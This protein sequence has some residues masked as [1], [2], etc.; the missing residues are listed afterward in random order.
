VSFTGGVN[1]KAS[2]GSKLERAEHADLITLPEGIPGTNC[3]NCRFVDHSTDP[4][5]YT[6]KHVE[7]DQEVNPRMCCKYWDKH[8]VKRAWI[9]ES[10]KE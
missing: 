6:C 3:G 9:K 7:V 10:D 5:K 1:K 2:E 4:K 8:G